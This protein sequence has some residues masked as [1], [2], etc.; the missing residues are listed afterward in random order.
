[1]SGP[2]GFKAR[3]QALGLIPAEPARRHVDGTVVAL[4]AASAEDTPY[5]LAA[6]AG[7]CQEI[8]HAGATG[9]RDVALNQ[10]C[11]R[12][13]HF[14][15][16]GRLSRTLAV[17][18]LRS[19][20]MAV[21]DSS[22][23]TS[24]K[25][26]EKLGRVIDQGISDTYAIDYGPEL[27][28]IPSLKDFTARVAA[29]DAAAGEPVAA[30]VL[31]IEDDEA[32]LPVVVPSGV[33]PDE[34][35]PAPVRIPD[36]LPGLNL[37]LLSEPCPPPAWLVEGR[38]TR[39]SLT[40]LG[41]KPGIGKSWTALDLAIAL[42][43]G[44]EWLG[45]KIPQT[46]RV[47]YIDVENGEVLARRRLQQLGA[48]ADAIGDRLHYVT[49]SVIFPGGEDSK[50]YA[51]TLLEFRPDLVVIDTLASSAPSAE[52]DTESMSLFLYDVWHR[53]RAVGAACLVLAHLRKSQQGAG[54]DD[55]LDSF[56]GAGHLVG[57]A[58][59]AWLLEP[60]GAGTFVLR[61]VK[62]REFPA[63][64]P[65]RV[66]LVDSEAPA[67]AVVDKFTAVAVDGV[68][69]EDTPESGLLRFQKN[70]LT[71]I[72]NH[73]TGVCKAEALLTLGDGETDK[74]LRNYLTEMVAA[75]VVAR[76]KRGF[77]SR[78]PGSPFHIEETA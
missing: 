34:V 52:S 47:L 16:D 37:A 28:P 33:V 73:P 64:P 15:R 66:A 31:V 59:R 51:D 35:V 14:I 11:L 78:P 6:L 53:A 43:T 46:S 75:G 8:V 48:Q 1:M 71:L 65:T 58:S 23:F 17:Q 41:S 76:P 68:E 67:G 20:A 3:A 27:D 57:A 29:A 44:R 26:D 22:D 12:A 18:E 9:G 69:D 61:D 2:M 13:G 36:P 32:P 72:D 50:R 54:K 24:Q 62:T 42:T 55:P 40:L 38:M 56:R 21:S 60:R 63:C 25:I 5:G 4:R 10:A 39:S 30:V 49:E 77:Y 7:L 74:T 70:V 45:A 19:A